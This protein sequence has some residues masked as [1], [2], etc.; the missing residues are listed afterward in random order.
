MAVNPDVNE[1]V[2]PTVDQHE[3]GF[4]LNRLVAF[5]GPYISI[6][7]GVLA[8]WLLVHVHLL[9]LFHTTDTEVANAI[10]QLI[11][12]TLV[13]L[14][15]WAGQ[16]KW[17]EGWQNWEAALL[18]PDVPFV[19]QGGAPPEPPVPISSA[20]AGTAPLPPIDEPPPLSPTPR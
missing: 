11:V 15:T 10:T 2:D 17:L 12:F 6:L 1:P 20:G 16:H 13:T 3:P 18:K 7:A 14:V 5:L 19:V 9:S 4:P 8:D